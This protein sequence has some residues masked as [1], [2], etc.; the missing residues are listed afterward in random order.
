MISSATVSPTS[1]TAT[2][3]ATPC[4]KTL[5]A[6]SS[7][8]DV[9]ERLRLGGGL[10]EDAF[11][12]GVGGQLDGGG[13]VGGLHQ[14]RFARPRRRARAS[15]PDASNASVDRAW[16]RRWSGRCLR[17]LRVL[18]LGSAEQVQDRPREHEVEPEHVRGHH[19][20]RD[21]HDDGVGDQL[22][23]GRPVDLLELLADLLE[24]LPGTR[25]LALLLGGGTTSGGCGR[26]LAVRPQRFFEARSARSCIR[27]ICLFMVLPCR[28][29]GT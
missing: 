17:S 9:D 20:D 15:S 6:A 23:T 7:A 18:R 21:Q 3:S 29:G 19:D 16:R 27:F 2:A 13:L 25:A 4:A 14:G 26:G 12:R 10:L 11:G 28:R 5:S 24:E 22:P 1:S 8:P